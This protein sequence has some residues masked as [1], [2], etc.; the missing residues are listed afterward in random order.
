MYIGK[1]VYCSL[2][3][4][5]CTLSWLSKLSTL[6]CSV[7]TWALAVRHSPSTVARLDLRT[8]H[9][10]LI[11]NTQNRHKGLIKSA[12]PILMR[13][14]CLQ[15]VHVANIDIL[16]V[17]VYLVHLYMLH[18]QVCVCITQIPET[19]LEQRGQSTGN[20]HRL[21]GFYHAEPVQ[22]FCILYFTDI[23]Q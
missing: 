22:G 19:R 2:L 23:E 1:C 8:W 7:A 18:A 3:L 15:Y 5:R 13:C 16:F 14:L 10:S 21:N 9:S 4:T 20:D 12:W 11:C 6:F 17:H